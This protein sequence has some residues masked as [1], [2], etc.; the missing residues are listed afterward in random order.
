M[1][2]DTPALT[3]QPSISTTHRFAGASAL[4]FVMLLAAGALVLSSIYQVAPSPERLV[5]GAPRMASLLGRMMPPA[6]DN[7]FLMRIA[8]Q[9][10]ETFQ[11]AIA[12]TF[13]GIAISLPI[14]WLSARGVTPIPAFSFLF[15][16]LVSFFRTV[17]DLVWALVFV[18]TVGLGAV[19]GTMTIMADTIGFCGRFFCESME[20]AEVPGGSVDH[21]RQ[22]HRH[23][24]FRNH[25]R[26]ASIAG[27]CRSVRTGESST[28]LGGTWPCW[29]GRH[30]PGT[31]G[32]LRPLP[33][34]KG[35]DDHHRN[36]CCGTGD[37]GTHKH[38]AEEDW[39]K[40]SS[41]RSQLRF[42]T[43]LE[44]CATVVAAFS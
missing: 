31:A 30:R 15:K 42:C 21:R 8:G 20:E 23:P 11:I 29:S 27:Q 18:A 19:A 28:S 22:P 6:M 2:H 40:L 32:R 4:Q 16:G 12:G 9:L 10:I 25:S 35:F 13:L 37:G 5:T 41:L 1:K 33:V 39:L 43:R 3:A 34:S 14:A 7:V 17:P 26:Y 24:F 44:Y 36:L 38:S